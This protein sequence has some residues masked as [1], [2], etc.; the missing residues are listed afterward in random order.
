MRRF[1]FASLIFTG[2]LAVIAPAFALNSRFEDARQNTL[3]RL[4]D[5]FNQERQQTLNQ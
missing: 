3:N 5:R 2:T 4:N 1:I